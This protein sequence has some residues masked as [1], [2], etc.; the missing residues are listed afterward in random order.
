[1]LRQTTAPQGL[2]YQPDFIS[3]DEEHEL[4]AHIRSLPLAPFQFGQYEGK[5]RV[6]WFG[7]RYDYSNRKLERADDLPKWIAPYSAR[8]EAFA[9]LPTGA[10]RQLLFTEYE[11]GLGLAGIVRSRTLT[12]YLGCRSHQ[13]VNFG[14]A[15]R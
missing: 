11:Q 13:P 5:R 10:V 15:A 4:V 14:S 8:V 6:A 7:W 9:G 2:R 12:K 1:M 3:A